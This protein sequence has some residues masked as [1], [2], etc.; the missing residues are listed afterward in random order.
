M[1]YPRP[2]FEL[3]SPC[4]FLRQKQIFK[5]IRIPNEEW[6]K[7]SFSSK[8]QLSSKS[9]ETEA[10]F[11][12]IE[13]NTRLNIYFLQNSSLAFNSLVQTT[14]PSVK[15]HL[16]LQ[17]LFLYIYIYIYI[18]QEGERERETERKKREKDRGMHREREREKE[19]E[20][21]RDL[22]KVEKNK[23]EKTL[24][25]DYIYIYIYI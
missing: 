3:R 17:I 20:R 12:K 23:T 25:N 4:P 22:L 15:V 24:N 10:L 8:Y 13:L 6:V 1:K 7:C 5:F 19:R 9:T 21:E 11:T 16:K 14:S 2:G 18:Y